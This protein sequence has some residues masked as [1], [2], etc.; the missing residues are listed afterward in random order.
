[1]WRKRQEIQGK[2]VATVSEIWRVLDKRVF[3]K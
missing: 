3:G 2:R 1:M